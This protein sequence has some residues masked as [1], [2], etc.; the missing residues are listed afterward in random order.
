MAIMGLPIN[1][2]T[3]SESVKKEMQSILY[4]DILTADN[5]DQIRIIKK[6]AI[7]EKQIFDNI[8][9]KKTDFYKPDNVAP[10]SSYE[11][12]MSQNGCIAEVIYN[13]MRSEDMPQINIEE[14]NKIMKIKLNLSKKNAEKIKDKYP[15]DYARL[16]AMLNHPVLGKLDNYTLGLP[17]DVTVPDWAL[18][19]VDIQAITS[20]VLN[21]F[22]LESIGLQRMDN[23]NVNYS[24]IIKL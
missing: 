16:I 11:A 15:E 18:E 1:K 22:P 19:F 14:R 3:L 17:I 24:N 5:I 12:P 23:D 6:L 2:S 7:L 13:A 8:M 21:N 9:S 10:I 4:E 20:D